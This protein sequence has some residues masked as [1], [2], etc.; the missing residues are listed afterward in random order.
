MGATFRMMGA[1]WVPMLVQPAAIGIA[2][3]MLGAVAMH[4]KVKDPANK[5]WPASPRVYSSGRYMETHD[6]E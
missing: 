1:R 5:S 4:V 6:L 3:L 2:I